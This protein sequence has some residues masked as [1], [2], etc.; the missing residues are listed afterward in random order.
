MKKVMLDTITTKSHNGR[1]V[2]KGKCPDCGKVIVR[3][4]KIKEED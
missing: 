1:T 2:T 3:C 4:G